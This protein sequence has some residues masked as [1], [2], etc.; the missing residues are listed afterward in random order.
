M[1][2]MNESGMNRKVRAAIVRLSFIWNSI[3]G[4]DESI[5]VYFVE[6]YGIYLANI[7]FIASWIVLIT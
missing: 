5:I 1:I 7:F 4:L 6:L 3:L 2:Y